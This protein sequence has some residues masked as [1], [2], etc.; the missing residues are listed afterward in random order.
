MRP[1]D[2]RAFLR[3]VAVA[4]A[5]TAGSNLNASVAHAES[6]TPP[7]DKHPVPAWKR[8]PCR[9]CGVGCG[10]LVG[11]E[12]GRAAAVKGDPDSSVSNGLACVKGYHCAQALYGR[13]RIT[14]AMIRRGGRLVGVPLSEALDLVARKLQE[15]TQQHGKDSV[16]VYGSAQWSITDAYI[17]SKLF[18]GALGTNNVET[19]TRLYAASAMSGLE[20]TFGLDGSIGCYEDIENADLFVVWDANLAETDPVL[21]GNRKFRLRSSR[22]VR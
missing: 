12:N 18:K 17:A 5:A 16:A 6:R 3:R 13:D 9:L 15:S 22:D 2:R 14:R 8:T 19:S 20:S 21:V 4:S 10:L 1:V 11:V 7:N